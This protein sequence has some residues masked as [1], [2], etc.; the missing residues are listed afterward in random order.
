MTSQYTQYIEDILSR[1]GDPAPGKGITRRT[2][3][4]ALRFG[5]DRDSHQ[6]YLLREMYVPESHDD[7]D[8]SFLG[9]LL[10]H[11]PGFTRAVTR[12]E[13]ETVTALISAVAAH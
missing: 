11:R 6:Y 3:T 2:A 5:R 10:P 13:A 8:G 4:E 9:G 1:V 7:D 12:I